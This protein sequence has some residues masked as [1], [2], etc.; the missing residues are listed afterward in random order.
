MTGFFQK[1]NHLGKSE[2]TGSA[3]YMIRKGKKN[4]YFSSFP[5]LMSYT[6]F[7]WRKTETKW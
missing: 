5:V 2:V 7:K 3:G 4:H 6:F 1:V